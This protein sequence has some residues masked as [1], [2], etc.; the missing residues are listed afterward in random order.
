MRCRCLGLVLVAASAAC[1]AGTTFPGDVQHAFARESMRRVE[2]SHLVLYYPASRHAEIERFAVRADACAGVLKGLAMRKGRSWSEKMTIVMPEVAFNNAYV[3]PK[4]GGAPDISV[5][6][7]FSTLDFATEFGLPPDPGF[8]ACH[9]LVHYVHGQQISGLWEAINAVAGDIY[10]PQVGFDPWFFEGLAT[11]YESRLQPGA[12]RPTWPLF[13]GMFA[14]GYADARIVGGDL[15]EL[16]RQSPVGHHYLVGTMFV[17]FLIERYGENSLWRSIGT[18]A[19]AWTGLLSAGSLRAGIGKPLA[20]LLAEFDLWHRK[21]FPKRSRPSNQRALLTVGNDARYA[22]GRDGSEAWIAD[23]LDRPTRLLVRGRDGRLR[24]DLALVEVVPPRELVVASPLLISGLSLSADG[25]QVWFTAIDQGAIAQTTRL[26]RW[27]ASDGLR[28]I[29]SGLGPGGTI[30]ASGERYFFLEVD[31]DRWSLA[32]YDVARRSRRTLLSAVAGTYVLSAQLSPDGKS[33]AASVWNG[34]AFVI[35]LIDPATGVLTAEL[36]DRGPLYDPA[37]LDD[38]RLVHLAAIDDRF[39]IQLRSASGGPALTVTDAPY[40]VLA[41]RGSGRTV[42]FLNRE[43]WQWTLDEVALPS[44][45]TTVENPQDPAGV[46]PPPVAIL[47]VVPVVALT[48]ARPYSVWDRFFLPSLRAPAVVQI[49][50]GDV[51]LG[52]MLGGGDVLGM[53]RWMLS[54]VAQPSRDGDRAGP[55]LGGSLSY[56]NAMLAPWTMVAE[57][58]AYH[59][60]ERRPDDDAPATPALYQDRKTRDLSLSI[61][62]SWRGSWAADAAVIYS[63]NRTRQ[64]ELGAA[65]R[66]RLGGPA[67][68]L[69][70]GGA[71]FT[72]Y[73]GLRRAVFV[74]L[75][76]SHF[77]Q[78]LSSLDRTATSLRA[79]MTLV[80]PLPL[81]RRHSLALTGVARAIVPSADLI[82]LG[83]A[84]GFSPLAFD[85]NRDEPADPTFS[86]PPNVRLLEPLRGYED[87]TFAVSSLL[88]G[89]LSWSYPLIIDRGLAATLWILPSSFLRQLD[90][91]L[92]AAGALTDNRAGLTARHLAAG[93]A[94]TMRIR[95]LRLPLALRY[96]LARRLRDD[97]ALTQLFAVGADL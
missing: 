77:P 96:Q 63:E 91:E 35:W 94:V 72:P 76:A 89:E 25:E 28:E 48:G 95:V 42:R 19:S 59:G 29:A 68:S 67:L 84:S 20:A 55:Y 1:A 92:F 56:A 31:G 83:G 75:A 40:T 61:G 43:G 36:T 52:A 73:T 6:P 93:G 4:F 11:H 22:R 54:A 86:T 41:P 69:S 79:R 80:E 78:R 30:D 2:T 32:T 38:G 34:A 33:L 64:E 45:S 18:Q 44:S 3:A 50:D 87:T 49:V 12:G 17:R 10:S 37:F 27:R 47:P 65:E 66:R 23:D 13:T 62:R 16:G 71:D 70:Y 46:S 53:H 14:A 88:A 82:E 58:S 39:Q 24:A 85:S 21:K 7:T 81:T 57:V 26:M 74:D 90:L 9:E 15:S 60:R 5:V 97:L 8:I 51:H